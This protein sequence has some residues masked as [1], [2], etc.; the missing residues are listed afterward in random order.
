ME[1][2]EKW[3]PVVGHEGAYEVSSRGR[4]RSLD[5]VVTYC[6]GRQC[7]RPGKM[8][9]PVWSGK[10][11]H[12]RLSVKLPSGKTH[13]VHTLVLTAFVGP[14]PEGAEGCHNDGDPANNRVENLRWD[15]HTENMRD[16][17]RQGRHAA[18]NKSH[19][20][21]GHVLSA[22]NLRPAPDDNPHH[23]RCRA[24]GYET[25]AAARDKRPI[26]NARCDEFYRRIMTGEPLS[27]VRLVCAAGHPLVNGNLVGHLLRKRNVRSCRACHM[28]KQS[29]RRHGIEY[30]PAAADRLLLTYIPVL[31]ASK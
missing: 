22:P 19:C 16:A 1:S 12:R 18:T 13:T 4:V 5:R 29:A 9:T 30:D 15:T 24:C 31:S 2:T 20:I 23:R 10:A 7:A 26:D 8:L 28:A 3:L 25:V 21:R 27:D 6:D 14:R 11:R 17:L